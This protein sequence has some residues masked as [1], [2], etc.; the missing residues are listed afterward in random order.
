MNII[1]CLFCA[2]M[3]LKDA[4]RL[5]SF[6]STKL[7]VRATKTPKGDPPY[8]NVVQENLYPIREP[9]APVGQGDSAGQ[10]GSDPSTRTVNP[11]LI[12]ATTIVGIEKGK[13]K[14]SSKA[15]GYGSKI[16]L[17]GSEHLSVEDEGENVED[18]GDDD[19]AEARPQ[20]SLKRG[21][22]TSSKSDPNPKQLKK[23]KL[24]FKTIVLDE[25]E[26]DQ[27]IGFSTAGGL[28]ENLDAH[29]HGSRT[30]RDQP[31]NLPSS[32]LS[33]GGQS[34]KAES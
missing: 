27:V 9:T 34:T 12:Q 30:P 7:D 20:V 23:K 15:K 31:V 21:R 6:D 10:G 33:F 29:L 19:D 1:A 4:L 22:T 14:G 18:E 28:L 17:Y 3:G 8:L 16:I 25:D 32:P 24:D 11:A 2:A 13:G 26:V 5:K